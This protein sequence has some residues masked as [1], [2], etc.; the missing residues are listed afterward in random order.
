MQTIKD[1]WVVE[2]KHEFYDECIECP[3]YDICDLKHY[4]PFSDKI[5]PTAVS[6]ILFTTILLW[7]LVYL[8][9]MGVI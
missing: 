6:V 2:C 5:R 3:Y 1:N 4:K 9:G 8:L 7:I